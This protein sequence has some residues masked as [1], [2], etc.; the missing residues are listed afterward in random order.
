MKN[1]VLKFDENHKPLIEGG[2]EINI[3]TGMFLYP[4]SLMKRT[5]MRTKT[6]IINS[7]VYSHT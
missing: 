4:D 3:G 5:K 1:P 2:L 7:T 6:K